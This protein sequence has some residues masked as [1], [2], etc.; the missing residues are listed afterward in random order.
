M[1]RGPFVVRVHGARTTERAYPRTHG[2]SQG[3]RVQDPGVN[4]PAEE[5]P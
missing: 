4:I 1:R 3:P 2:P 5:S